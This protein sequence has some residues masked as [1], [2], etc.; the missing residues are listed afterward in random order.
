MKLTSTL[1]MVVLGAFAG[2]ASAAETPKPVPDPQY[3]SQRD[4]DPEK[5]VIQ[6]GPPNRQIVRTQPPQQPPVP[7]KPAGK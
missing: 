1:L 6:N 5:C 4:A 3:C 7:A 2:A